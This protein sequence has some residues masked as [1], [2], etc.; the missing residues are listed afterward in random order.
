MKLTFAILF[1]V[2]AYLIFTPHIKTVKKSNPKELTSD[3]VFVLK[4]QSI[5]INSQSI[6]HATKSTI[7]KRAESKALSVNKSRQGAIRLVPERD[8]EENKTDRPDLAQEQEFMRTMNPSL[9]RPTRENLLAI[10][11][12]MKSSSSVLSSPGSSSAPWVE[13]H[14]PS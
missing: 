1:C 14:V 10:Y 12:Q 3:V 9:G 7:M 11:Q 2:L 8:Q 5:N 4:E 6:I 13:E